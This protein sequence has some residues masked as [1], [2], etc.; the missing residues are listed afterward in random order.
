MSTLHMQQSVRR[1]E[2]GSKSEVGPP[3]VAL[4]QAHLRHPC[5]E[6]VWLGMKQ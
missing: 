4:H 5:R 3:P 1:G 2:E 6:W